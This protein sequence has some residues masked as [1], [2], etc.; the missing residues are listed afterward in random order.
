MSIRDW[1]SAAAY[2]D[3]ETAPLRDIAWEYLRRNPAFQRDWDWAWSIQD[4]ALSEEIAARWGLRFPE[5]SA[6]DLGRFDPVAP[7]GQ[8]RHCHRVR[9]AAVLFVSIA[10]CATG[11]DFSP[12]RR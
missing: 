12:L 1:R 3:L 10:S 7:R 8:R 2:A 5:R 4:D 11:C 6:D 9:L